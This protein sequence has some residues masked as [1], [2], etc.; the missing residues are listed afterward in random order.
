MSLTCRSRQTGGREKRARFG[1][2]VPDVVD[3]QDTGGDGAFSPPAQRGPE[4]APTRGPAKPLRTAAA[5]QP[6]WLLAP[7]ARG[8]VLIVITLSNLRHEK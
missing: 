3:G 1:I 7:V 5:Q 6:K 4:R 8:R 2:A